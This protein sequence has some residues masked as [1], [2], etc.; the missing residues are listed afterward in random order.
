MVYNNGD[1]TL[2]LYTNGVRLIRLVSCRHS[3]VLKLINWHVHLFLVVL[4]EHVRTTLNNLVQP[5]L[6]I[7]MRG[8]LSRSIFVTQ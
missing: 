6:H 8:I 7:S 4:N 1:C 3:C 5:S 2:H